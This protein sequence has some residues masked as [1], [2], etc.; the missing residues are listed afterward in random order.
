MSSRDTILKAIRKSQR[1]AT[2]MPT[3]EQDWLRFEDPIDQFTKVLESVGGECIRVNSRSE[4]DARLA[5]FPQFE[6]ANIRISTVEGVGQPT[7]S[8]DSISDPHGLEM[9]DFAVMS[10]EIAVGENGAVW[11]TDEM[12]KHRVLHFIAQHLALVVP[13]GNVVNNMHEAYERLSFESRRFGTFISGPS[14]TADIEQSLVIGA[15]GP[16]SHLVFLVDDAV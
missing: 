16:R 5:G 8:M 1:E 2:P 13:V 14:K 4:I 6:S 7:V 12:L 10:G 3:L 11:V 9:V 15:H